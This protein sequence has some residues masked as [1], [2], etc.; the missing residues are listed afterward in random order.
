MKHNAPNERIK[1]DYL[2]YLKEAKWRDETSIDGAAKALVRFE[3][4]TGRKDFRKLHR[5]QAIAFKLRLRD[6]LNA[7]TGERLSKATINSTLRHCRDFFVWLAREPGYK[8]AIAYSDADYFSPSDKDVAIARATRE[9]RVP[10]LA[11][12]EHVLSILPGGTILQRRDRALIAFAMLTAVRVAA[13]ASLRL[14]DV[15]IAE[16][17]V[18]QDARH[19]RTKFS[20]TIRTDFMP[21]SERALAIVRAWHGELSADATRGPDDALFPATAIALDDQGAFTAAGLAREGWS[22]GGPIR[23]VFRRA[24]AAA[25]IP[26]FNPHSFRHML[27]RYAMT[28]DLTPEAMKAWSQNLGH[29]D[30]LTTFTSYGEVPTHRQGELIR[31]LARAG[32]TAASRDQIA[33]LE[34]LLAGLKAADLGE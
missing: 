27:A 13:L 29:N 22:T 28:L 14:G 23:D 4:S 30:V 7:R 3:D 26:Y 18:I 8:N 24:F 10:T 1:R 2:R 32:K 12:V 20:K 11:Q 15:D 31:T 19:V 21:V 16:G 34:A 6:A 25:E 33:S 17:L 5:E 9:K